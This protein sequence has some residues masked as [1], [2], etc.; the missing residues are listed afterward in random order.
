MRTG[1]N[2]RD[3]TRSGSERRV[4]FP[5]FA[6][7]Y[8]SSDGVALPRITVAPASFARTSPTSRAW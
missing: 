6:L 1:G 4:I 7:R 5:S 8:D 3:A 2:G